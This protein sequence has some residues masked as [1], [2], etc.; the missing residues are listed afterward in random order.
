MSFGGL[1]PP[2]R[3]RGKEI[4]P[5]NNAMDME[6]IRARRARLEEIINSMRLPPL[7]QESQSVHGSLSLL[8]GQEARGPS[9]DWLS[10]R[11]SHSFSDPNTPLKSSTSRRPQPLTPEKGVQSYP[12]VS[13][14]YATPLPGIGQ[15]SLLTPTPLPHKQ[16]PPT[17]GKRR[18]SD[19]REENHDKR[20]MT[21][22]PG[23]ERGSDADDE[24][25]EADQD[26]PEILQKIVKGLGSHSSSKQ[27]ASAMRARKM[28]SRDSN[29]PIEGFLEA[30]ILT[31]LLPLMQE[32]DNPKLQ[33]E[34]TWALTNIAS[35]NSKQTAA[36]VGSG[37][38]PIL[39]KLLESSEAEVRE[40]AAWAL[41]NVAGD[42]PESRD[43]VLLGGILQPLVKIIKNGEEEDST[44]VST[45][46]VVAWVFANLFRNKKLALN[47]DELKDSIATLKVLVNYPDEEV[48]VD[49]LWALSYLSEQGDEEIEGV[50]GEDLLP[51]IVR[52]LESERSKMV[53]PALRASGNIVSGND[54]QTEAALA[55][56]VL[57]LY[58]LLLR[59]SRRNIR[60]ETAWALSN[61]TA[62]TK[63]QIQQVVDE[64]LLPELVRVIEE[65]FLD[66]QKESAWALSNLTSGGTQSQIEALVAAGGVEALVTVLGVFETSVVTVALE[67]LDNILAE[68]GDKEAVVKKIAEAGGREKLEILQR[69]TD[70]TVSSKAQSLL[71]MHFNTE[72]D[73][74]DESN[75][76]RQEEAQEN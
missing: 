3:R 5:S 25:D 4:K 72:E 58:K 74:G 44:K 33:L 70:T 71:D 38:I 39:V 9:S 31:P 8:R 59:N 30:G 54:A 21:G 43:A 28:L 67:G 41:G 76:E 50:L 27:L 47:P 22:R 29:P 17:S 6:S 32:N 1:T 19:E 64:G 2:L 65:G 56:G 23:D 20:P 16:T 15:R 55:A 45:V 46:R 7:T 10:V 13:R 26:S 34:A 18:T 48:N 60:K 57:P 36:V 53:V 49:A 75:S 61:V 62:G 35:G 52:H 14:P 68:C 40:Q 73:D 11:R 51:V 37:A 63:E 66:V 12:F 42:G 24:D 69:N